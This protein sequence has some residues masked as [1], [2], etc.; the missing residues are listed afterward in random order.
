MGITLGTGSYKSISS[1]ESVVTR[2]QLLISFVFAGYVSLVIN[3]WDRIRNTTLGQIWGALENLNL[4]AYQIL[5]STNK[6]RDEFLCEL[7]LR[8]SRLTLQLTF[9]AAQG[10]GD[11]SHLQEAS[12]LTDLEA[13]H[14]RQCSVGTRP[15]VVVTWLNQFFI[16]LGPKY[17]YPVDFLS[18]NNALNNIASLRGGI[19]ATLG[20]IGTQLPYPYVHVVYWTIQI[21]LM[22]LSVETGVRLATFEYTKTNGDG[23]YSPAD[24]TVSWPHN[25]TT[26]FANNLLNIT[27]SNVVYA[28]FTQGVLGI[29]DK[30]SN[31]MSKDDTSFSE[32][33]FGKCP[34]G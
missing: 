2:I 5:S 17:G 19:G 29:C 33:V 11:L 22:C 8:H 25:E 20:A 4:Q 13:K 34:L 1:E 3:R 23:N 18:A 14:L 26:W 28:L 32:T 15:L 12:L 24:D 31:P 10:D 21:L 16:D 9:L 6:E 7:I 30:L 27:M